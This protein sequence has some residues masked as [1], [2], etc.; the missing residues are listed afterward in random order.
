MEEPSVGQVVSIDNAKP[1]PFG[2]VVGVGIVVA[3]VTGVVA[4]TV[5]TPGCVVVTVVPLI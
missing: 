4:G 1:S 3:T 2:S 5:V